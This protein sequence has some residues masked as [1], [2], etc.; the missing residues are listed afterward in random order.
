M[1]IYD[2]STYIHS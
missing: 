2:I 1:D